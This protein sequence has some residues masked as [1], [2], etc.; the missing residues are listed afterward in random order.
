MENSYMIDNQKVIVGNRLK[1]FREN[2]NI[3]Q[4]N[5]AKSL[6]LGQTSVSNIESGLNGISFEV[7]M[8]L[9]KMYNISPTWLYTGLG[10]MGLEDAGSENFSTKKC[11]LTGNKCHFFVLEELQKEVSELR[12]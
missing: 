12:R 10:E 8:K 2:L 1:V 11:A 4:K 5:M 9:V 7:I 3:N 6:D